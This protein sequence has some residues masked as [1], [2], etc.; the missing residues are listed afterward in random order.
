VLASP[1]DW[2]GHDPWSGDLDDD[3]FIWGRGAQDMKSQTAAEVI[4]AATLA[5]DGWRPARGNLIVCAV[6]DEETGGYDGAVWLC[7]HHGELVRGDYVLNEGA[8]G[9]TP[10]EGGRLYGVCCA[11]KGVARFAI[12]TRG[13]AGHASMPNVGDNALLK[14]APIVERLGGPTETFD[15]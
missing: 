9:V 6:V 11:E 4:A 7:E 10:F 5:K 3:G 8:G 13:R 14:L 15:V 12:T 1:E 2:N